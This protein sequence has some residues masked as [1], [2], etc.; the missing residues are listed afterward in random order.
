[1]YW[2]WVL[3]EHPVVGHA[4]TQEIPRHLWKFQVHSR[5]GSAD[6]FPRLDRHK[7]SLHRPTIFIY[8]ILL[9]F[10]LRLDLPRDLL[11][12]EFLNKILNCPMRANRPAL[13][14]LHDMF[15][16]ILLG[17]D[18]RSYQSKSVT[19]GRI[20][21]QWMKHDVKIVQTCAVLTELCARTACK[22]IKW[23]FKL[24]ARL[25]YAGL[26]PLKLKLH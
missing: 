13:I 22:G 24:H 8:G 12:S 10:H 7:Y 17:A 25:K 15:M 14:I 26:S 6:T 23:S 20:L 19:K 9:L 4:R 3:L 16:L 5:V 18:K 21:N 1:M 2:S 11:S